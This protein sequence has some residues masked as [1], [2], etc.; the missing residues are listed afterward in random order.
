MNA[1]ASF[2]I[3]APR[4][5]RTLHGWL[6]RIS[7]S[8]ARSSAVNGRPV[9]SNL[10]ASAPDKSSRRERRISRCASAWG[11]KLHN[12]GYVEINVQPLSRFGLIGRFEARDAVVTFATERIYVTKEMRLT[13]GVRFTFGPHVA[14][15]A[16]YLYNREYGGIAQFDNDI[17]TTSLVLAY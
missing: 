10:F 9:K 13:G 12:S 11:L 7:K 15:K 1:L 8:H 4:R 16:E 2:A 6:T 3:F 14:L 17:F 5:L